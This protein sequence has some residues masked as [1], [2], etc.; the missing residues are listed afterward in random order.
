VSDNDKPPLML[1]WINSP[2]VR[3]AEAWLWK[4][5]KT[6]L[7][8]TLVS[9]GLISSP[10]WFSDVWSLFSN[11]APVPTIM[12]FIL[13]LPAVKFSWYWLPVLLG[14]TMLVVI[15]SL[16]WRGRKRLET[17]VASAKA[18]SEPSRTAPSELTEPPSD[19]AILELTGKHPER[20]F[21]EVE[22]AYLID[23]FH[24]VT[25]A[26]GNRR[27]AP[28]L[29]KWIEIEASI[30]NVHDSLRQVD[31]VFQVP[32]RGETIVV[33]GSSENW[34]QK[35]LTLRK[36]DNVKVRGQIAKVS[37]T[38]LFVVQAEFVRADRE[39]GQII[40]KRQRRLSDD[41]KQQLIVMLRRVEFPPVVRLRFRN[42]DM[43]T[44]QFVPDFKDVFNEAGWR[45]VNE[46][47]EADYDTRCGLFVETKWNHVPPTGAHA[48]AE[49]LKEVGLTVTLKTTRNLL[50]EDDVV[51]T[52]GG[53]ED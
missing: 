38:G 2:S 47:R 35:A 33:R 19:R 8:L 14:L 40:Y 9:F 43:E 45:T 51:F 49:A 4:R 18:K 24:D 46:F 5:P 22:P 41:Q 42:I 31:L 17:E 11:N 50:Y 36:G 16:L 10:A 6:A 23:L 27:A 1:P 3:R 21:V 52:I 48:L 29:G 7:A 20:I 53:I 30:L 28:Y 39:A 26:E 37:E 15:T 25:S 32:T 44:C 34:K 12:D 13:N